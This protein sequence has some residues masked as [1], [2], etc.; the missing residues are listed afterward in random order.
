MEIHA[1]HHGVRIR[2][3]RQRLREL[4]RLAS[5]TDEWEHYQD[6]GNGGYKC[7]AL[8]PKAGSG[9]SRNGNRRVQRNSIVDAFINDTLK[10][11]YRITKVIQP[12]STFR[13]IPGMQ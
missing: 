5:F 3:R 1:I 11:E 12:G 2:F 7:P 4:F 13:T 6:C 9:W 10:P 8:Q